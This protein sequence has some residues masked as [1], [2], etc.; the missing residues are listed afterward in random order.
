MKFIL[1]VWYASSDSV[2]NLKRNKCF[3]NIFAKNIFFDIHTVLDLVSYYKFPKRPLEHEYA[4]GAFSASPLAHQM[5]LLASNHIIL[6][7][8]GVTSRASCWRWIA[9]SDQVAKLIFVT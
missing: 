8:L 6:L 9:Y 3:Y 4:Y 1:S 2:A 7:F 5:A